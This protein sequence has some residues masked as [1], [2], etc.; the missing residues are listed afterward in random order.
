[1]MNSFWWGSKRYGSGGIS[2]MQQ[3]R[4]CKPKAYGGI[5]FK[6][7]YKFNVATLGRQGCR[8]LTNLYS[9]VDRMFK[10]RY[11]PNADFTQAKQGSNLSYAWRSIL[12]AQKILIPGSRIQ[13]GNGQSI[14]IGSD[15][16]LPDQESG[17]ITTKR[18]QRQ[19]L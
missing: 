13:V 1:M 12:A 14:T 11:Y 18:R 4:L 19:L 8:L 2:W 3:G 6:Y 5:G 9:L 17:F 15:P 16:W 10:A 7:I